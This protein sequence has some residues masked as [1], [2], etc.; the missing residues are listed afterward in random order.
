LFFSNIDFKQL[1]LYIFFQV[2][3]AA[4]VLHGQHLLEI[5]LVS[6][7]W[8]CSLLPSMISEY[9]NQDGESRHRPF[10]II[11]NKLLAFTCS[12][13]YECS[14]VCSLWIRRDLK[15]CVHEL[16]KNLHCYSWKHCSEAC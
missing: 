10:L 4:K 16:W 8:L 7:S 11:I 2:H 13:T 12:C 3:S 5:S 14:R 15:S 6:T 9:L 1:F